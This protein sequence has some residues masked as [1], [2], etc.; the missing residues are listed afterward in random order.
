MPSITIK[1]STTGRLCTGRRCCSCSELFTG[2]RLVAMNAIVYGAGDS[3]MDIQCCNGVV[4]LPLTRLSLALEKH[5][6]SQLEIPTRLQV[7]SE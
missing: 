4:S 1:I 3:C 6:T 5:S 7:W 2:S